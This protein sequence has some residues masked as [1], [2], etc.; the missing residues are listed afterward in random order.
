TLNVT[1]YANTTE[2]GHVESIILDVANI[3][4]LTFTWN[5]TAFNLGNYTIGTVVEITS[6]ESDPEQSSIFCEKPICITILGD[7]DADRDVD[8]YDVVK[9]IG[10]YRSQTADPNYK[11]NLD[12]NGDGII[13]IYDVV[14]CTSHYGQSW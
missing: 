1:I 3:M 14:I 9:I 6:G 11:P 5:T 12:I 2:I 4:T 8:I 13:N 7:I 10:V